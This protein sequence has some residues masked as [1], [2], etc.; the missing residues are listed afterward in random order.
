MPPGYCNSRHGHAQNPMKFANLSLSQFLKINFASR[1]IRR[2]GKG[3]LIPYGR[4]IVDVKGTIELTD[5][6]LLNTNTAMG[7]RSGRSTILRVD[8]GGRLVVNGR[9]KVYYGG[10]IVVFSGGELTLRG[11]FMNS[12]ATIRCRD[13]VSIGKGVAIS[14][15][16]LIQD[17]DGHELS[18]RSE[19]CEM[20]PQPVSRPILID[21]DVLIFANA[22]ILKGVHI[23]EGAVV[24]AGSVVTKDVPA[25]SLVAGVPAKVIRTYV[26]WR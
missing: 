26:E 21:K 19:T 9:F 20:E 18:F 2:T 23:G 22:T 24:A 1:S 25:H 6:L 13:S 17:Y 10:D 7:N 16:T 11:G 8:Q 14:H 3:I 5:K 4:C 15:G 12:N